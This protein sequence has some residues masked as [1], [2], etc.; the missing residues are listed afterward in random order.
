ML[1]T[2]ALETLPSKL[3]WIDM[4]ME[5]L[6]E[7]GQRVFRFSPFA[8]WFNTTGR[9]PMI[10]PVGRNADEIPIAVQAVARFGNEVSLFRLVCQFEEARPGFARKP[11]LALG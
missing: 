8:V 2:P 9:P 7:Y 10:V 1:L 3:G 5:D 4:V 11:A 6:D